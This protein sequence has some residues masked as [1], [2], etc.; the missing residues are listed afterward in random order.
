MVP[1]TY[2]VIRWGCREFVFYS[3]GNHLLTLS[4]FL[5]LLIISSECEN[6]STIKRWIKKK[7]QLCCQGK[8]VYF[9]CVCYYIWIISLLQIIQLQ[10][11][12]HYL[13]WLSLKV[14]KSEVRC[15]T[16][17]PP[18][19]QSVIISVFCIQ[20]FCHTLPYFRTDFTHCGLDSVSVKL[21]GEHAD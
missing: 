13:H 7:S 16:M 15:Y 1:W 21:C 11:S 5:W 18:F 10:W 9:I 6:I 2:L 14:R 19:R 17:T 4:V 3:F 8:Y 12:S 20:S